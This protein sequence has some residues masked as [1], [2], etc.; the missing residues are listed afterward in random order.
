MLNRSA[1]KEIVRHYHL[2]ISPRRLG[3]HFLV[4]GKVLE[5]ITAELQATAQDRILEIGAGLGSLTECLLGTGAMVYAVERDAR[6]IHV[7]TDRF[8]DSQRIQVVR[9]DILKMD[10]S[11][12]AALEPHSLLVVGNIPYSLTSPILEFLARQRQWVRRAVLT[13]QKEV[14]VRIVAKPGSKAYSNLSFFVSVAF[15]PGVAF[16]IP[17]S[18]FY[19]QPRVTSAV[20]RL[21]PL[22]E[23]V[24]PPEEEE[25]LLK[26][27]RAIFLHR[28][29]TLLNAIRMAG[30]VSDPSVLA[31]GLRQSGIDPNRRPETLLLPEWIQLRRCLA[32][33]PPFVNR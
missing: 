7:L 11:P 12:Y 32:P 27:V 29:K 16:T 24:V 17:P 20:L 8:K 13:I 15:R 6:F 10:L 2:A 23:P 14:A 4:G 26:F 25:D 28:R 9:S 30:L 33:P 3:Q 22:P 31:Q 19:P 5:R 1:I 21:D 18:F